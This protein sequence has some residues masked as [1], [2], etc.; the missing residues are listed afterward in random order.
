MAATDASLQ[1]RLGEDLIIWIDFGGP[2]SSATFEGSMRDRGLPDGDLLG[3][4]TFD[5]TNLTTTGMVKA[6][7]PAAS[8]PDT[9]EGQS[10][11]FQIRVSVASANPQTCAGGSLRFVSQVQANP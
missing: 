8:L 3:T 5:T 11:V 1:V 7:M 4:F 2:V 10:A 6:T 9:L